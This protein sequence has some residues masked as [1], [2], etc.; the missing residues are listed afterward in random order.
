MAKHGRPENCRFA[1]DGRCGID[2][3]AGGQGLIHA[4]EIPMTRSAKEPF[5]GV[6]ELKTRQDH[7]PHQYRWH[8][9]YEQHYVQDSSGPVQPEQRGQQRG[10][11]HDDRSRL[12]TLKKVSVHPRI[13]RCTE[14][15]INGRL[16]ITFSLPS[17]TRHKVID[18][19]SICG[20]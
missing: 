7:K 3:T 1:V 19:S 17:M 2:P 20:N 6:A 12:T 18:T 5:V 9:K 13:L 16:G 8:G 10:H 15:N 11:A 14:W 4:R